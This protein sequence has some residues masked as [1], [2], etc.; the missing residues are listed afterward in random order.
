MLQTTHTEV[1]EIGDGKVRMLQHMKAIAYV[2]SGILKPMIQDWEDGDT[3]RPHI[4]TKAPLMVSTAPDGLRRIHPTREVDRYLEMGA[5]FVKTGGVWGK[6]PLGQ[7]TRGNK[8][9]T[10]TRPNYNLYIDHGGHFIKLAILLKNGFIPEDGQIAFPV[11]IN[12]LT[13][14]GNEIRRN[15]VPVLQLRPLHVEDLDNPNDVR[16]IAHQFQ[17]I[18]GQPYMLCTLPSLTGMGRPLIDPTLIL[19]PNATD[20]LDNHIVSTTATSNNGT[21]GTMRVGDQSAAASQTNRSLIKF[22]LSTLSSGAT[23]TSATLSLFESAAADTAGLGSWAVGLRRLLQP[24]V[25]LESTYNIYSTGNN[26]A[27]AGAGSDGND[28]VASDSA[29]LTL[30][31]TAAVGFVNWTH[32]TLAD[33]VQKMRSGVYSNYGW[34]MQAPTAE[35]L[36]TTPQATNAFSTSDNGTAANRPKLEIIYTVPSGG[37]PLFKA[38]YRQRRRLV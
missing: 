21:S 3:D 1:E 38:N 37:V 18:N 34:L 11:G 35:S 24:W 2:E 6:V 20:G 15:G 25:E 33:D 28:R 30:D 8:R 7:P 27:T 13:R 29:S 16:P 22:D 9:L 32:A 4:V 14:S 17:N 31:G 10:W 36:G 12:G 19:Q 5:P 23:V 26:W